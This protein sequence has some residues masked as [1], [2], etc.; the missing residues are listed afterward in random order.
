MIE[1]RRINDGDPLQFEVDVHDGA[2]LTQ[3]RVTMTREMHERLTPGAQ[4]TPEQCLE[5]AFRFLLDRE[6]KE[7]ILQRFDIAVIPRYFADFERQLP[8][9]LA[10]L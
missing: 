3:H 9:Y 2:G 8:S 1:I 6:P 4:H 7:A 5:A 10:R